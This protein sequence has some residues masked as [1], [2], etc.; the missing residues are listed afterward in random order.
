VFS[1]LVMACRLAMC[2]TNRLPFSAMA[3]IDGVVL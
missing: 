3:T 1:A 2:P